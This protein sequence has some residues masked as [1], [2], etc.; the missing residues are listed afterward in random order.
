VAPNAGSTGLNLQAANTV[1]NV[2]QPWNPAILEQRIAR[3]HRMGQKR[4]V[5]V[6]NLVTEQ[7][8][9]E[10]LLVTLADKHELALAA[11]DSDSEIDTLTMTSG[12]EALKERLEI[13][14]GAKPDACEDR[15]MIKSASSAASASGDGSTDGDG[16][17]SGAES[18]TSSASVAHRERLAAAGGEL[19]DA[20]FQ[21]LDTLVNQDQ[22]LPAPSAATVSAVQNRFQAC[23]EPASDGRARLTFTLPN[24]NSISQLATTLARMLDTQEPG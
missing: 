10:N 14:L 18:S 1:I 8:L 21:F 13:L 3:A 7:T 9:E 15:S 12:Q 24:S 22:N 11:L 6:F 4:N 19:L 2:D 20:V 16:S 5:Q 23:M 17:A